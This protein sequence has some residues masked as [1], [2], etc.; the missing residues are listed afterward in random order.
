V[1]PGYVRSEE[2]QAAYLIDLLNIF[3][4]QNLY[5]AAIWE[6]IDPGSPYSTNPQRDLDT[7]SYAIVK[8]IPKISGDDS[9]SYHWKRKL[10][11]DAVAQH[12]AAAMKRG[13]NPP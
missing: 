2:T 5:A 6:F 1:K 11:F 8:V 10:A 4:Q 12:Y 9:S 3:E 7:G 13:G